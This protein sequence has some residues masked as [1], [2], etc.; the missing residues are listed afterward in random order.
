VSNAFPVSML[1][2]FL[3]GAGGIAM[4]ATANTMIQLNVPDV[5][6]GRV[7]SVYTTVF[8]GSSPVGGLFI[9]TIASLAGIA[10]A[11][12]LG[13]GL[14]TLVAL[15]AWLWVRRQPAFVSVSAPAGR[16]G[17]SRVVPGTP[18]TATDRVEGAGMADA[19]AGSGPRPR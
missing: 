16:V 5:L 3:I 17:P 19:I 4:A 6:R 1:L 10:V 8:A 14:A 13:G 15:G 18:R 2:M 11:V 12:A 9:G 7:M